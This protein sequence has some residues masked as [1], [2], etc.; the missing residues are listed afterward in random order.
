MKNEPLSV[1]QAL[2]HGWAA[3]RQTDNPSVMI[4]KRSSKSVLFTCLLNLVFCGFLIACTRTPEAAQLSSAPKPQAPKCLTT[5]L[6]AQIED[7]ARAAGSPVGVGIAPLSGSETVVL[8]GQHHFPMQSVYKLPIGMAVLQQ[9]DQGKL[10][11]D[12]KVLVKPNEYVRIGQHSPIRD[13]Y[14]RGVELQLADVLRYAVSESDGTASDVLM[15]VAGGPDV[16]GKYLRDI[17]VDGMMVLDTEKEIGRSVEVQYRNWA[18]P[19]AALALLRVIA[20]ERS[21]SEESQKLLLQLITETPTGLKRIKGLL[22]P[23][24]VVAHKT[25][26]GGVSQ[27]LSRA[28]NDIGLVTLPSGE[29]LAVAVFVSDTKLSREASEDL[30]AKISRAAWDCWTKTDSQSQ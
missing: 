29:R 17:G 1:R 24:T 6:R 7:L 22:P 26:T 12:Q 16:V 3:S 28:V 4:T 23:G 27:G 8:N 30:I 20:E 11:L 21:L 19:E 9:I 18:T 25:G 2:P 14:P 15:R 10:K 13:K 5:A